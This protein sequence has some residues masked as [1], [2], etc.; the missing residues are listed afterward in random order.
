MA[1]HLTELPDTDRRT[2]VETSD[3]LRMI[4]YRHP[5]QRRS[6]AGEYNGDQE[7]GI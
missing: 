4:E 5:A 3:S 6:V 2:R 7:K 1:Q